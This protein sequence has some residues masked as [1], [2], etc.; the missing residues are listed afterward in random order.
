MQR[1]DFEKQGKKQHSKESAQKQ[2]NELKK[3]NNTSTVLL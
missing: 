1:K 3:T 2:W